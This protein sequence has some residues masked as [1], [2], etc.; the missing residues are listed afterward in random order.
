MDRIPIPKVQKGIDLIA[1][2]THPIIVCECGNHNQARFVKAIYS[3][4][5]P[6][7]EKPWQQKRIGVTHIKC[8]ECDVSIPKVEFDTK[9]A[10]LVLESK[11]KHDKTK[12]K[13]QKK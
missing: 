3:E 6:N 11:K 8:A 1:G 10:K 13:Q 2:N 7:K 4:L 12:A 9:A 5:V